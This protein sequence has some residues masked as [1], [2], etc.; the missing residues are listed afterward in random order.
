LRA[1]ISGIVL[2]LLGVY[3]LLARHEKPERV[4]GMRGLQDVL[5][6]R[7]G[8]VVHVIVFSILPLLLGA[9]LL[10]IGLGLGRR[11]F[12]DSP[13]APLSPDEQAQLKRTLTLGRLSAEGLAV[14]ELADE[15]IVAREPG[16]TAG[17]AKVGAVW[18]VVCPK[19][20]P[21]DASSFERAALELLECR[22][23]ASAA[24]TPPARP[25]SR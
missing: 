11:S 19:R 18:R 1:T 16:F 15:S 2:L 23:A 8:Y 5:G 12:F 13:P 21:V 22:S 17:I 20:E 25:S 4:E 9:L 7:A 14:D 6:D 3:M 10:Y 24:E